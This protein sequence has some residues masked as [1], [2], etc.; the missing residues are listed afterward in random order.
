MWALVSRNPGVPTH[1]GVTVQD[2]KQLER[3]VQ[4]GNRCLGV[5]LGE[6]WGGG[7]SRK[8]NLIKVNVILVSAV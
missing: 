3:E 4:A 1:S 2:R 8:A 7:C 6:V 5:W